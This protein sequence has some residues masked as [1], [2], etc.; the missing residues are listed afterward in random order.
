MEVP[1]LPSMLA[2]FLLFFTIITQSFSARTLTDPSTNHHNAHQ[3]IAFYMRDVFSETQPSSRPITTKFN[4]DHLPFSKPLGFFPPN[5]GLPLA[6]PNPM[7]PVPGMSTQT[8]DL[9]GVSVSFPAIATLQELELGTVATIED[10]LF[11]NSFG[12]PLLGKAQGMYVASSEDRSS[13]MM[14]MTAAF[15]NSNQKDSL[16]FFGVHRADALESHVAIIGGMGK[17]HNA[18]GYATI[19]TVNATSSTKG[20]ES[21]GGYKFLLFNVYLG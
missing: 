20:R 11:K 14:A 4:G 7:V 17:F 10:D 13:H 8:L 9:S 16:R 2:W 21:E 18:N 3:S 6:D 15:V 12:T 1:K 5:G 19:K